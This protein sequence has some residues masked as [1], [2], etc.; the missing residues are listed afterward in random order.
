MTLDDKVFQGRVVEFRVLEDYQH[1]LPCIQFILDI[2]QV[3]HRDRQQCKQG[4]IFNQD[5]VE[6]LLEEDY[7]RLH[8]YIR[9]IPDIM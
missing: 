4:L 8:L 9:L 1:L 2:I 5:R 6:F 7:Q 3:F